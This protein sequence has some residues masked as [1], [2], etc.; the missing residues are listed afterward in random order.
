MSEFTRDNWGIDQIL[1]NLGPPEETVLARVFT[2]R[3]QE[4]DAIRSAV[5]DAPRRIL[6]KGLFGAGKTVLIKEIRRRL[7]QEEPPALVVGEMLYDS[8]RSLA[9]VVMRGLVSAL[10][11]ESGYAANL[12]N[13]LL[14]VSEERR[15]KSNMKS[16][17]K[18]GVPKFVELRTTGEEETERKFVFKNLPPDP[19]PI[20]RRLIE[21]AVKA[22]PKR[23][24]ILV[25]DDLD[26]RDPKNVLDLLTGCRPLIHE[27]ACS[28][29]FTGHPLGIMRDA[30]SSAGGIIDREIEVP[31]MQPD[32]MRLMVARYLGAGRKR[33]F[34]SRSEPEF[35]DII[36]SEEDVS[37]FTDESLHHI[38]GKSLGVPRV[39]NIICYNIL[40]EAE[41][42]KFPRIGKDELRE[43]WN[44]CAEQLRRGIK[45]DLRDTLELMS[46]RQ[47]FLAL[48]SVP[49][50]WYETLGLDRS[51]DMTQH[52]N[53]ALKSDLLV[54]EN[55][56][57]LTLSAIL[58]QFNSPL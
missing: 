18:G 23:R 57:E 10:A 43:C 56:K 28:F 54:S 1:F 36:A 19:I 20:V 35:K 27:P 24:I 5:L 11:G 25:I 3:E 30:Y 46:E 12:D 21:D 26:K 49:D 29:V 17:V 47:D 52:L 39:L 44:S 8:D 55:G 48:S 51:E 50:E 22:A 37:P 45:P 34:L 53:Y 7:H 32:T 14:G 38:I 42:R 15:Q 16:E 4:M 41:K 2:G 58:K 31:V 33:K 40:A 9:L 13:E 6:I